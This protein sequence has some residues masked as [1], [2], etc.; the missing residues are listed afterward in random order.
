[1][2]TAAFALVLFAAGAAT[3]VRSQVPVID[4]VEGQLRVSSI[5]L[6]RLDPQSPADRYDG[7]PHLRLG[8]AALIRTVAGGVDASPFVTAMPG[9]MWRGKLRS[10]GAADGTGFSGIAVRAKSGGFQSEKHASG[11]LASQL[12]YGIAVNEDDLLTVDL[13]A[14]SQRMPGMKNLG[15]RKS[16]R[17]GTFYLGG[18][19]IHQKRFSLTGGW[20]HVSVSNLS[21]FDYAIE[22]TAG[23]PA[24]GQGLRFGFDWRLGEQGKIAPARI[25]LE[26][27]D[28]DADR[29]RLAGVGSDRSR[30]QRLL[31]RFTAPF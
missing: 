28:G 8:Q 19:L 11:F 23:M 6:A 31:L 17:V 15:F 22:R 1:M 21:S 24:P 13:S 27:R 9:Q 26:L 7:R 14:A 25:G 18:A 2:R 30:E 16:I 3:T 4:A 10:F 12:R 29:D 20:Y 5:L